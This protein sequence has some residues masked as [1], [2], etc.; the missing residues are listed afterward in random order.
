MKEKR[1]KNPLFTL[2]FSYQLEFD[3]EIFCIASDVP[4]KYSQ[5][6]EHIKEIA[7]NETYC[8]YAQISTIAYSLASIHSYL[9]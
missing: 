4:Y 1:T 3:N 6:V 9:I 2:S 7:N 5:M 8:N